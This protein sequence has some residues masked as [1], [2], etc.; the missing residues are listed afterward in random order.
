MGGCIGSMLGS[1]VGS[2]A[3]SA[4][5]SACSCKCLLSPRCANAAYCLILMGATVL[6]VALRFG[7]VDL[8]IGAAIGTQGPTICV[9]DQA[10]CE[11]ASASFSICNAENCQ[12]YWA[13]YRI[14]F[15]L[16]GFFALMMLLT[17]CKLESSTRIHRG[18]WFAKVA[19]IVLTLVGTLFAPNALFAYAAWVARF[20]APIFL[21]YQLVIFV[22]FSYNLNALLLEKDDREDV[23]CGCD[24]GGNKYKVVILLLSLC[25][26][27]AAFT[28]IG[29]MYSM[30]PTS[31][32]FNS[33]A[34]T[35]TLLFGL[36][37]TGIAVSKIAEHG[38]ILTSGFIFAYSTF[39]CYSSISAL[40]EPACN[41]TIGQGG[42]DNG[43]QL[44]VSMAIAA[45]SVGY[46]AFRNGGTKSIGGNAMSGGASKEAEEAATGDA[47]APASGNDQITVKVA[48]ESADGVGA[49]SY[50]WYH[51]IMVSICCYMAMLL[52]DW[53]VGG[54]E[55]SDSEQRYSIGYA[56][57]WL[58]MAINWLCCLLYLWTLIAP[59]CLPDRDFS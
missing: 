19:L 53:G 7:K 28:G 59:K 49:A 46:I 29:L 18:Y 11:S 13:V 9:G 30:W 37:N 21:L 57:A 34:I 43:G 6:G 51:L 31:C 47:E 25:L 56:S 48:G 41:P 16:G 36:L 17:A 8:N 24:N 44:G 40:P 1:C 42:G 10:T 14:A 5:C 3:L 4:C 23:F 50:F 33:A 38:S 32:G 58:Q 2:C 39:L 54:S 12:G 55:A 27:T 45:L 20:I 26:Y 35:L 52:T 22:D 15:T